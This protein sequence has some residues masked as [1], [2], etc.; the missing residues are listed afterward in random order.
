MPKGFHHLPSLD[1]LKGFE[2]V[3][4]TLSFTKAAEDLCL[5][6]SAVSRQIQTLE[7]QL[8]VSLFIRRPRLLLLTAE[9]Q[10]LQQTVSR[11]LHQLDETIEKLTQAPGT[12][13]LTVSTTAAFASLW[14]IP[15]L[16]E[17]MQA[18]PQLEVRI[19]TS[20]QMVDLARD[21]VDIAIRN[22]SPSGIPPQATHLFD[23]QVFPVC[24]PAKLL[25]P[26]K[27]LQCP[28]DLSR[29]ALLHFLDAESKWPWLSW[30]PWLEKAGLPDLQSAGVLRFSHY[31]QV[32]Q[33]A[34]SGQGVALGRSVLVDDLLWNG[35]L[36]AP[37]G[38]S[39]QIDRVYYVL[40]AHPVRHSPHVRMF[41]DWLVAVAQPE[42]KA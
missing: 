31:E 4:R 17:F 27:P 12:A 26:D 13:T 28:A 24:A 1:T 5:T 25:D 37:F 21:G 40:V 23:E 29:H 35:Q 6:Q 7:Q 9:G 18:H 34:I 3:A 16:S 41:V 15:R 39:Q 19:S 36:V 30:G 38:R 11:I 2:A 14:L 20:N 32:I 33:A 10:I 42:G 22:G 8:G